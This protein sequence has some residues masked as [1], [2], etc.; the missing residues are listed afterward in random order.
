MDGLLSHPLTEWSVDQ[1]TKDWSGV[2]G[3]GKVAYN[4]K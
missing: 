2:Y 1:F 3:E 4:S